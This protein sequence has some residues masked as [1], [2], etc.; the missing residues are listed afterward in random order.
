MFDKQCWSM[1]ANTAYPPLS[2]GWGELLAS[3]KFQISSIT[4]QVFNSLLVGRSKIIKSLFARR[5]G[6]GMIFGRG[7]HDIGGSRRSE[8]LPP[9][10]KWGSSVCNDRPMLQS[11]HG[12]HH[13]VL[14][15]YKPADL[16]HTGCVRYSVASAVPVV[17]QN[18]GPKLY[19]HAWLN[20]SLRNSIRCSDLA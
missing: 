8:H 7:D 11:T 2:C 13:V 10:A 19:R 20:S 12:S 5:R 18:F 6:Q 4:N 9:V 3:P 17:S 15:G 1:Q 14:V 16:R